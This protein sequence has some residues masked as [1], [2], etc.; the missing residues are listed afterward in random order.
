VKTVRTCVLSASI[1]YD[2]LVAEVVK[3]DFVYSSRSR[4]LKASILGIKARPGRL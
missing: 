4:V 3:P 1:G 2:F